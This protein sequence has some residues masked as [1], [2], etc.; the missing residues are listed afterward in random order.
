MTK[1]LRVSNRAWAEA[2]NLLMPHIQP[3]VLL[4]WALL[5]NPHPQYAAAR[6]D[7]IVQAILQV[8]QV[9]PHPLL[10]AIAEE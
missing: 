4:A 1:E 8:E 7:K 3:H 5:S 10:S 2:S 6:D 9:E